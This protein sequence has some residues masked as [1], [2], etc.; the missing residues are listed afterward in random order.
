MV[1]SIFAPLPLHSAMLP[2]LLTLCLL[3]QAVPNERIVREDLTLATGSV[4]TT[5]LLIAADNVTIRGNG[6]TVQGPVVPGRRET[7]RGIGICLEGR[8]GV[9][10]EG[11][12]VRGFEIG[13]KADDCTELTLRENDFS[14]NYHDPE[15]GWGDGDRNGGIVLTGV[16]NSTLTGNRANRVWNGLDLWD[17][18]DN[19]IRDNDFSHCSNVCLKL[20]HSSRNVVEDNDL[21]WG[22]RM[23]PGEVHAR[24]STCVLIETGSDHNIFQR[25]DITHG[26][27]GVFIRPLNGWLSV[28]NVFIEN[29]CSY[30][31]NNGFESWSPGNTYLRNKANHCS[32]G[33]WLGGSD[34]TVLE[35][36]EAAY[37]GLPEGKHNAP[38]SDFGHGGIVI[39]HG[40][41]THSVIDG[42]HCHHNQGGG[43]VLRG[44]LGTRGEAWRMQHVIVQRNRL[45]HNRYGIFARFTDDLFLAGNTFEG[46]EEDEHL[47]DVRGLLRGDGSGREAPSLIMMGPELAL[48]SEKVNLAIGPWRVLV[49]EEAHFEIV[50]FIVEIAA[51]AGLVTPVEELDLHWRIGE[52]EVVGPAAVD[53][54]FTEPGFHR[55]YVTAIDGGI[56]G[57][58]SADLY[59]VEEGEEL[60]TEG[61]ASRWRIAQEGHP[62]DDP[63]VFV[64]DVEP[65]LVGERSLHLRPEPY[66]GGTVSLRLPIEAARSRDLTALSSLR[67][68]MRCR[69]PNN[70][71]EGPTVIHLSAGMGV[72]TY[73]ATRDGRPRNL[74]S[75][76]PYPEGR[77]GWIRVEMPLAGSPDWTRFDGYDGEVP[78]HVDGGLEFVTVDTPLE[79]QSSTAL[80]SSGEHL[81]AAMIEG[82]RFWR[83]SDGESWESL[84]S[85]TSQL[86]SRGDWINGMLA[87]HQGEANS[88]LLLRQYDPEADEFG[89]H[90]A[91]LVRYDVA[92]ERWAWLPTRLAAGH[93]STVVGDHLFL[94]AHAIGEN[95]GGPITRIDLRE[96][97]R[98]ALR[99]GLLGVVGP[100]A[101]W[102]SRTAQLAHLSG[103]VYATKND[104][105]T[106][107]PAEE[108]A[109][110]DRLITFD[111]A[112][113]D[114]SE[115]TGGEPW[116]DTNW[117]AHRT[118][119]KDLGT[120]P[121]E[122]GHG[123]ALVALPPNWC[124]SI[125]DRGG[126][127]LV[128]GCSPSNHEGQGQP[129][130]AYALYD[131][132]TATFTR[133]TL[134]D[135]TGT[136]T[137]AA[138]HDGALYIKRGGLNFPRFNRELWIVRPAS[139]EA[140][141]EAR[142]GSG[143]RGFD[144]SK[145]DTLQLQFDSVGHRP[146]SVWI[147]GLRLD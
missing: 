84:P 30:A 44:D 69:N 67:F 135:V 106:P 129:S 23:K 28:G 124:G 122:I 142:E 71:F 55:V 121:F 145:V 130:D 104:W 117:K 86:G 12:V 40:T 136:A 14:D 77:S 22:L 11:L 33:F 48:V 9:T 54:T 35:G 50:N 101:W 79:T 94:I 36:N 139:A 100:D 56:A 140:L 39:V 147:D 17:C 111:P 127:F 5:P 128:A 3:H 97:E 78:P 13:L 19:A 65:A 123:S 21:S 85:A 57:L 105:V 95:Y 15:Y 110:G 103:L 63:A 62:G 134:P 133:G 120:L 80:A 43:I 20:W 109:R 52:R 76:P 119:A 113:F 49:G 73:V 132:A 64:E 114:A 107:A 126:L 112:A 46:N 7:L 53:P 47:E 116:K 51:M 82:D 32:Y 118:P 131:V 27:D 72:A 143:R 16:T 98:Q 102:F 37:N 75:Q 26:G 34:R 115:F 29:D 60:G 6:A 31:N 10:V 25:N 42:N 41:G 8:K 38:E 96:P 137:S 108:D 45:E 2:V 66:G 87:F 90:W 89:V 70:G 125:G 61:D 83:S 99:T 93:G 146:F 144:F 88:G 4:L 91:R 74:L 68:W 1:A 58:A 18:D 24:D 81:Y 59:V 92:T 138:F 141:E